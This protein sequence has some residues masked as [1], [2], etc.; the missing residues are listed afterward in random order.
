MCIV[1]VLV[2]IVDDARR[3]VH[4]CYV[5]VFLLTEMNF[6]KL[7]FYVRMLVCLWYVS[8]GECDVVFYVSSKTSS[9]AKSAVLSDSCV[10]WNVWSFG[11]LCEFGFL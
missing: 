8:L 7:E 11:V 1:I 9:F 6:C 2:W 10:L 5:D 4:V 3:N